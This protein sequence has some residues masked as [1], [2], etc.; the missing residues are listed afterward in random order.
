MSYQEDLVGLRASQL[1]GVPLNTYFILDIPN[2]RYSDDAKKVVFRALYLLKEF[3]N[4]SGFTTDFGYSSKEEAERVTDTHFKVVNNI[5]DNF[6]KL[7]KRKSFLSWKKENC[8]KL[9]VIL[10]NR[11]T[12]EIG[13]YPEDARILVISPTEPE[14]VFKC[15]EVNNGYQPRKVYQIGY[16]D[17]MNFEIHY[18]NILPIELKKWLGEDGNV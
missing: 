1:C 3:S 8:D 17:F 14:I 12:L 10:T 5:Y 9:F 16:Q 6:G 7:V 13:E 4:V 18:K 11:R 2:L 15:L